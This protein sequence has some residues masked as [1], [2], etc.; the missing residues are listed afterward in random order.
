[1]DKLCKCR[2]ISGSISRYRR[3]V[4]TEEPNSPTENNHP[5]D[6][7]LIL[8]TVKNPYVRL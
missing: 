8:I 1:M 6:P 2:V 4:I 7:M 3:D 5:P